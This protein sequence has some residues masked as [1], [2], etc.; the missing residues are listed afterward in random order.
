MESRIARYL[1]PEQSL[2]AIG[3]G[4]IG[5]EC[6]SDDE[7]IVELIQVLN[8]ADTHTCV[9]AER[10]LNARLQGSCQ[11]P[12]AGYAQL[13]GDE[14]HLR[15]LVGMPDGSRVIRG[16]VRGSSSDAVNLGHTLAEDLAKQGAT[17]MLQQILEDVAKQR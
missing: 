10:G 5:I 11:V 12:I 7:Q 3:Q 16:A 1:E 15:G 13:A 17:D 4:A 8:D 6:R 2:P 14:L 9:S